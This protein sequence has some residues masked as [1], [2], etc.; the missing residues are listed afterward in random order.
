MGF[1][2]Y[3]QTYALTSTHCRVYLEQALYIQ[4]PAQRGAAAG[5]EA[6]FS[7]MHFIR[8]IYF[9][10][11]NRLPTISGSLKKRRRKEN[12]HPANSDLLPDS[13][14]HRLCKSKGQQQPRPK[15][16]CSL[17]CRVGRLASGWSPGR[18]VVLECTEKQGKVAMMWARPGCGRAW[19]TGGVWW[20]LGM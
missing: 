8:R 14:L 18:V 5:D 10:Y 17:Y 4:S 15:M 6:I 2:F 9:V 20:S 19:G 16:S 13:T 3:C 1:C 11:A 12:E 7:P